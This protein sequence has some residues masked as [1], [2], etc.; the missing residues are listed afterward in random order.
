LKPIAI[1]DSLN[2]K[3]VSFPLKAEETSVTTSAINE[4]SQLTHTRPSRKKETQDKLIVRQ[5]EKD[6]VKLKE[7]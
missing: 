2:M 5:I 3:Q 4:T 1:Y 7:Q 6:L